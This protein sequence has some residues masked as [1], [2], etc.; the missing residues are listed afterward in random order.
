MPGSRGFDGDG[1]VSN[2]KKREA[3]VAGTVGL[4]GARLVGPEVGKGDVGAGNDRT[5]GIADCAENI[6][7]GQLS[8]GC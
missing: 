3:V 5:C 6:S 1:V 7:S 4:A 2:R 8:E